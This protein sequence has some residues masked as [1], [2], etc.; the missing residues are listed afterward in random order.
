MSLIGPKGSD[1]SLIAFAVK[2]E[3]AARI[4]IA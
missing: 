3:R 4:R 1:A 2:F